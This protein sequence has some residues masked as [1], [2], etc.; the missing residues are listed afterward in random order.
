MASLREPVEIDAKIAAN[1]YGGRA[2]A[3]G[4]AT[5]RMH[6]CPGEVKALYAGD[7][8]LGQFCGRAMATELMQILTDPADI[9]MLECRGVAQYV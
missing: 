7:G 5:G 1:L 3:T 2:P 8:I 6:E 4:N 9:G